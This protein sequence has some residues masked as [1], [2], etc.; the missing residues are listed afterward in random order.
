MAGPLAEAPTRAGRGRRPPRD[1]REIASALAGRDRW[2]DLLRGGSIVAVVVGHW[3]VADLVYGSGQLRLRSSLGEA[4][5][6]WPLTWAFQV[7]PVFF[8]VAGAVNG[9]SWQRAREAG[10][11][12]ASFVDRR[13]HRVWVPTAVMLVGVGTVVA[14]LQLAD[15]GGVRLAGAM[16]LQPLWFL[17]IYLLLVAATPWTWS[18]YRRFGAWTLPVLLVVAT[19]SDIGRIGLGV[20]PAGYVNVVVVWLIVY[21]LGHA[22]AQGALTR[23][24]AWAMLGLGAAVL[25]AATAGPYPARMVGVPGDRISNMNP[26]TIAVLA[27]GLAQIGLL[28]LLRPVLSQWLQ[29]P[30][31]WAVVVWL[32]L[33]IMTLYL[34]HQFA[35]LLTT[36]VLLAL[37][38]PQ[39]ATGAP[40]WWAMRVLWVLS[41]GVVLVGLV[42]LLGRFEHVRT[43]PLSAPAAWSVLGAVSV[44][45]MLAVGLL[46]LAGTRLTEPVLPQHP[47]GIAVSPVVAAAVVLLAGVVA[48][49][50]RRGPGALTLSFVCT[51]GV[52]A[53]LALVY[54]VA[55]TDADARAVAMTSGLLAA[56]TL[57]LAAAALAL[58]RPRRSEQ[59]SLSR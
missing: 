14:L 40:A 5:Q 8:F 57:A 37:G 55:S 12:Y 26:P 34:W 3:L 47:L 25:V 30:R 10:T 7:I 28:V 46:A 13:V 20:A 1:P 29:R 56:S 39:P 22:F 50:N 45:L 51:A 19:L 23:T 44:V 48:V 9:P 41:A 58:G 49:A 18:L 24:V 35:M 15:G 36:R 4:P 16:L 2:L 31:A 38:A 27:L 42:L 54:A 6:L 11:G 43:P 59:T 32:N 33:S 21:L 53:L 17:A 52:L